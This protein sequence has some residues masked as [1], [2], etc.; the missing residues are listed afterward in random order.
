MRAL[1]E[2]AGR[3]NAVGQGVP[4]DRKWGNQGG[5][6]SPHSLHPVEWAAAVAAGGAAGAA[7]DPQ[8]LARLHAD[9]DG[10]LQGCAN[11]AV[12][13]ISD[14]RWQFAHD[15]LRE[16]VLERLAAEDRLALHG[17]VALA[18]EAGVSRRSAAQRSAAYHFGQAGQSERPLH[19][20]ALAG[21][22]GA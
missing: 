3:L 20:A 11:A 6:G 19:Y 14:G 15:K 8:V 2:E 18:I 16:R 7:V 22:N 1:A 12:L 17:E 4:A 5:A 13:E 9:V 10:W 21:S